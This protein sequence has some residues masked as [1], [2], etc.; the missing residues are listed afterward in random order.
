MTEGWHSNFKKN[1]Y[2]KLLNRGIIH[3]FGSNCDGFYLHVR[4]VSFLKFIT[5]QTHFSAS[6]CTTTIPTAPE[7]H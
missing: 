2:L 1:Y 4:V 6:S 7:A 3:I 5:S